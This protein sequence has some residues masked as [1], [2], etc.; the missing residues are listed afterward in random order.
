MYELQ[1]FLEQENDQLAD[2][3]TQNVFLFKLAYFCDIFVKL[4]KLNTV[5]L[6]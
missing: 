2:C 5:N 4:N 1:V 6:G 3:W